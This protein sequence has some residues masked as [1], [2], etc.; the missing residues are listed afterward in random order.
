[1]HGTRIYSAGVGPKDSA[2]KR[3]PD[4]IIYIYIYNAHFKP[5]IF[6]AKMAMKGEKMFKISKK[7]I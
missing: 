6:N 2:L 3:F 5:T 1:V 4:I 7:R